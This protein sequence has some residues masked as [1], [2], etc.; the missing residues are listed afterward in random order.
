MMIKNFCYILLATCFFSC[1]FTPYHSQGQ[2]RRKPV[3]VTFHTNTIQSLGDHKAGDN[4]CQTWAADDN[5]YSMLDDGY[6]FNGGKFWYNNVPIRLSGGPDSIAFTELNSGYPEY[7]VRGGYY[8][9]G[10]ISIDSTLYTFVSISQTN[11]FGFF[12]GN[13]LFYS[14]DFGANW[15]NHIGEPAAEKQWDTTRDQVFFWKEDPVMKDSVEGYAFSMIAFCQNGKDNEHAD[16]TGDPYVYLYSPEPE[17]S[18][19]LNMARVRKDQILDKASYEYFIGYD[20]ENEPA[21]TSEIRKRGVVYEFPFEESWGWYS[22]MPSVVWNE[23]LGYYIMVNYGSRFGKSKGRYPGS[24]WNDYMHDATCS[25][26]FWYAEQP[27]GPWHQIYYEPNFTPFGESDRAYQTKLN[28]K[29][30]E[31]DGRSMYLVWSD[32]KDR[33]TTHYLWNQMKVTF[34]L[35]E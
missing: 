3:G 13:K 4:W 2:E 27:W 5:V 16:E 11:S 17:E 22:W 21:W 29:W 33:W 19:K 1:E 12:H 18:W 31:D 8:G 26:G 32:A 15:Y 14:P 10:I 24:Y 35:E 25:I 20:A 30:I 9:Y 28:P 34:E 23:Q 6:G 7:E